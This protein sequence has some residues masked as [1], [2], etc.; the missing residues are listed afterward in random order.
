VSE[1]GSRLY[2]ERV[3]PEHP[4]GKYTSFVASVTK[5]SKKE[6]LADASK[7]AGLVETII[8]DFKPPKA[9]KKKAADYLLAAYDAVMEN[10]RR[11]LKAN[12]TDPTDAGEAKDVFLTNL[13]PYLLYGFGDNV[14]F[15]NDP[16]EVRAFPP[17]SDYL[18][19]APATPLETEAKSPIREATPK[20]G[21]KA[22]AATPGGTTVEAQTEKPA[23]LTDAPQHDGETHKSEAL[24]AAS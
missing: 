19:F 4:F 11:Y 6:D 12:D 5:H 8:R 22:K 2:G 23:L 20:R 21:L 9:V 3:T 24:F 10:L 15:K 7:V 17:N 1:I 18:L 16:V 13:V 14:D